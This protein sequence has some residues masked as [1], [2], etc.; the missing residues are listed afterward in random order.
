[1]AFFGMVLAGVAVSTIGSQFNTS[2]LMGSLL[3]M[4]ETLQYLVFFLFFNTEIP[5]VPEEFISMLYGDTVELGAI[6][7]NF[8]IAINIKDFTFA[9]HYDLETPPKFQ[10]EEIKYMIILNAGV[11][12]ILQLAYI[13]YWLLLRIYQCFCGRL[14]CS[15]FVR[16][17][18]D[19][20][21]YGG[22][23]AMFFMFDVEMVIF[24][25]LNI[26]Q[27]VLDQW[28]LSVSIAISIIFLAMMILSIPLVFYIA[29]K[30]IQV[31]EDEEY[32]KD[33]EI[34]YEGYRLDDGLAKY[35]RA[36]GVA[37]FLFFGF[38]LV[39]AY[40]IPLVQ[41]GGSLFI[42]VVYFWLLLAIRPHEEWWDFFMEAVT[43]FLF[44]I[45]NM[46]FMLLG[47]DDAYGLL[48]ID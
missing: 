18:I 15:K 43:E 13:L 3:D 39:F 6:L 38:F 40:Y 46:L 45:E 42:A 23:L 33:Y 19:S 41:I 17:Q 25:S 44:V 32:K 8:I 12:I 35:F 48:T 11:P 29:N 28:I 37:R 31:L 24:A 1:M 22:F 27:P 7:E 47:L 5:P 26:W 21:E 16:D 2:S 20:I 4:F 9:L 30:P 10:D 14:C 34:I 36:F